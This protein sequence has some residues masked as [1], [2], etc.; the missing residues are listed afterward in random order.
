MLQQCTRLC[1]STFLLAIIIIAAYFITINEKTIR[2]KFT[3]LTSN[4]DNSIEYSQTYT[5]TIK[6]VVQ[7]YLLR[8][9]EQYEID[10]YRLL[11]SHPRDAEPVIDAVKKTDEYNE[12]MK[13]AS[14][15]KDMAT[16]APLV[17]TTGNVSIDKLIEKTDV[18]DK[19]EMYRTII[20]VYDKELQ[21]M[22][23]SRELNY[24]AYRMLTDP[25]FNDKKLMA[26]LQSSREY[27]ILQKNQSNLVYSELPMNATD[28]QVTYDVRRMYNDIFGEDPGSEMER[29]L[30]FKFIEMNLEEKRFV[31]ML[32]LMRAIDKNSIEIVK[33]E[34]GTL[35]ING[36]NG[37][38]SITLS[39]TSTGIPSSISA[40]LEK[41][42]GS[43]SSSNVNS[44][45]TVY[46]NQ[47]IFNIINPSSDEL[48][49]LM[50]SLK[51]DNINNNGQDDARVQKQRTQSNGKKA[52]Q[53]S[54]SCKSSYSFMTSAENAYR[55]RNGLAEYQDDR[56]FDEL[57]SSCVRNSYY[58]NAD[59]D[60]VLFPEYKWDVPQKRPPV[61]VG[62]DVK[63]EPMTEQTAL[64]GT[65]L[66]DAEDTKV[67]SMMPSFEYKEYSGV[68]PPD[69]ARPYS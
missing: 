49:S 21:R 40:L 57:R 46:N 52:S 31:E 41:T 39:D 28:A 6:T 10:R 59:D 58:L 9:P 11:M 12:I 65:L 50:D 38:P 1:K 51:I 27:G 23:T 25:N 62:G 15:T 63:V 61:C 29:F 43:P 26:I 56:N 54:S 17:E 35:S 3:S 55:S 5:E 8:Q 66:S 33:K 67:G 44:V 22:P 48:K 47:R 37:S 16:L 19:T 14:K 36:Q 7:T 2:E 4:S 30:K 34:D 13:A 68:A 69:D 32:L 53:A 64:I 24:Y 18:K 60:M 20:G 45:G 42:Q